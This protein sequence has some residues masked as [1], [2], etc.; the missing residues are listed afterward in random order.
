MVAMATSLDEFFSVKA[1]AMRKYNWAF[2]GQAKPR[3]AQDK[4]ACSHVKA[5]SLAL[6]APCQ[7]GFAMKGG[8]EA[9]AH[10]TR[11]FLQN[12]QPGKVFV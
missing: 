12:M 8:A 10:T 5:R 11:I 1:N 3:E 7:L 4:V 6:L 9:A 2:Q